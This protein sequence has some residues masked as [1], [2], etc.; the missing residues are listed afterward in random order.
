VIEAKVINIK[1]VEAALIGQFNLDQ[2]NGRG[3][4]YRKGP[5]TAAPKED[6][7]DGCHE[8]I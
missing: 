8:V 1:N 7:L 2:I 5:Q 4:G 3:L 6:D